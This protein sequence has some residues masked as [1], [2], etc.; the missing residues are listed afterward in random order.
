MTRELLHS[1]LEALEKDGLEKLEEG[2]CDY[3]TG[4]AGAAF[5]RS[6]SDSL[7][8]SHSHTRTRTQTHSLTH[9][10]T[11]ARTHCLSAGWPS[12]LRWAHG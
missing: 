4:G 8:L 11:H 5:C 7:S 6:L 2:A 3:F 1:K 12:N 9:S 10:L